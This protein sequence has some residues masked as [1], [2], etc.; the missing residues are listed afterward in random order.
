MSSSNRYVYGAQC[1]VVFNFFIISA[2]LGNLSGRV[3]DSTFL[4]KFKIESLFL[5][6][7]QISFVFCIIFFVNVTTL[8][9]SKEN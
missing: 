5:S 9:N 6:T 1:D 3:C 7:T 4:A 8:G 2:N